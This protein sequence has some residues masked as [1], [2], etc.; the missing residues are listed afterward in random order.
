M[1]ALAAAPPFPPNE[2]ENPLAVTPKDQ[3][4]ADRVSALWC[5]FAITGTPASATEWPPHA[6]G[7]DKTLYL[8]ESVEVKTDF[9]KDH[10]P[11]A[12]LEN[13]EAFEKVG[14]AM[15]NAMALLG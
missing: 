7:Q 15:D 4:V 12:A 6:A 9:M 2:P 10:H 1:N 13:M 3:E 14:V 11:D 8:G 5:K